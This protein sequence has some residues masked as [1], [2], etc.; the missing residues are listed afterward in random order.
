MRLVMSFMVL[1]FA[2]LARLRCSR[3]SLQFCHAR[4]DILDLNRLGR[5]IED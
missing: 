2:S 4:I 1:V 5:V 3:S